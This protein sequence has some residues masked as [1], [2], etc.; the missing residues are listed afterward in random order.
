MRWLNF[1][2]E[3]FQSIYPVDNKGAY[4]TYLTPNSKNLELSEEEQADMRAVFVPFDRNPSVL[5]LQVA[6]TALQEE[7]D[8]SSEVNSFYINGRKQW[9]D[10]ATRVGLVNSLNVKKATGADTIE[11]WLG[12]Q[13][14]TVPIAAAEQFLQNLEL[15]AMQCYNTT[16]Q[17]LAEIKAISDRKQLMEYNITKDYPEPLTLSI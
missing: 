7:Y 1:K 13:K 17:H 11:L 10:K 9:L 4:H 2:K 5:Q 12:K 14:L 8:N 16:A 6:L 15:Y 3:N